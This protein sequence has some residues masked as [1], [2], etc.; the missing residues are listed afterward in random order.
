MR[1]GIGKCA[2]F[3]MKSGKRHLSDGMEQPNQD[4][5]RTLAENET[6]KYL[7]FLE[8]D[9]TKKVEMKDKNQ[10]E[11]LSITKKLLETKLTC[12][13]LIKGM[14]TWAVPLVRYSRPFRKWTRDELKQIYQRTRKLMKIHKALHP[15]DDVDRDYMFQE[16]REE[17]DL[18]GL[19]TALTHRYNDSKIIYKNP[20]EDLL[21]PLETILITRWTTER[22]N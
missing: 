11:Y 6:N 1:Y 10:T 13:N 7:G 19:K 21:Q 9:I 20:M 22:H 12:R 18:A 16:K 15:R 4:K 8:A 2:M 14:N 17:E 5:I 3:V